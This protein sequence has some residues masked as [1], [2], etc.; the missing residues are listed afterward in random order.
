MPRS[1]TLLPAALACSA[2]VALSGCTDPGSAPQTCI[3]WVFFTTPSGA[4]A[5]SDAV[6][7]GRVID[8][9]GSTTYLDLPATTWNVA[10]DE[11]INGGDGSG[12]TVV[13]SLPRGCGDTADDMADVAGGYP[14][15]LFL[16]E[17]EQGW[18]TVTALQGLIAPN[19]DGGIPKEWPTE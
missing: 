19:A 2:L 13:T 12:M 14:V 1:R 8:A 5:E 15:I 6:I 17:D 18:Q 11:W 16:R 9:A 10:V 4:A 7:L 3:D